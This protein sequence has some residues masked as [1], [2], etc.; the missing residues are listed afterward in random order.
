MA[1]DYLPIQAT[2]VPC[3]RIFSSASQTDTNSRNRLAPEMLEA[4]QVLKY[5]Y[6]SARLDFTSPWLDTSKETSEYVHANADLLADILK[7]RGNSEVMDKAIER[8]AEQESP[9]SDD[10]DDRYVP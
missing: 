9:D 1:L 5:W 7:G 8:I 2:S 3:E 6:R 10:D 4:L